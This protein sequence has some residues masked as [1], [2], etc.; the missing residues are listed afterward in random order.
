MQTKL[1]FIGFMILL[2]ACSG[3][4]EP[5]LV[6]NNAP[7]PD[8]TI[9]NVLKENYVQKTYLYLIGRAPSAAEYNAAFS[10]LSQNNCSVGD[11]TQLLTALMQ[12]NGYLLRQ[13]AI[14]KNDILPGVVQGNIDYTINYLTQESTDTSYITYWHIIIKRLNKM[15]LLNTVGPKYA[16]KEIT[17]TQM[18]RIL[19][20]NLLFEYERGGGKSWAIF[21]FGYFTLRKPTLEEEEQCNDMYYG[22]VSSLFLQQG[23][24]ADDL[25]GIFFGSD[26]YFAGQIRTLFKRYLYRE[27]TEQELFGYTELYKSGAEYASIQKKLMLTNEYL[28]I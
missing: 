16:Q 27:P 11:R 22:Y 10:I 5:V 1:L 13:L 19:C 14:E 8:Y 17:H 21:C 23:E 2:S 3:T 4:K 20:D 25:M 26:A 24:S 28:G 18:Q 6:L 12:Q 7:P 9:S 15:R